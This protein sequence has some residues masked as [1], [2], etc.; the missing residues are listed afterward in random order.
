MDHPKPILRTR[1]LAEHW[2]TSRAYVSKLK[3]SYS[4]GGKS[5]PDFFTLA[6]ADKWRSMNAPPERKRGGSQSQRE[7]ETAEK[8]PEPIEHPTPKY[9]TPEEQIDVNSFVDTEEEFDVLMIRHA[10][11]VP[12]ICFGLYKLAAERGD[13]GALANRVRDWGEA[14]KQAAAVRSRFLDIK[15]RTGELIPL[16]VCLNVV[17]ITLGGIR[18]GMLRLGARAAREA[19]PEDPSRAQKAIDHEVDRIFSMAGPAEERIRRELIAASPHEP[20][21][22]D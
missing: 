20:I 11:E 3:R 18:S 2:G 13:L 5:M 19:N 10:E 9:S 22:S 7:N 17:G 15:Q 8:N 16:D 21:K 12:Q 4:A 14:T 6:D 1:D